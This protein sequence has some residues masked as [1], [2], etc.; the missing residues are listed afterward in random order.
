MLESI[1][2]TWDI[3]LWGWNFD[4]I[5][6]LNVMHDVSPAVMLFNQE[7]MRSAITPF[8][9]DKTSPHLLPLDKCFGIPAYT[10]SPQGALAL[11]KNCFPLKNFSLFFPV[12]N[13]SLPNKGIDIA[14]NKNYKQ[15]NAYVSFP[16]MV[17]TKNDHTISTIQNNKHF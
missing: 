1:S 10:I 13:R 17:V 9:Q 12:L 8:Q 15:L 3:I 5:L 7:Q 11:K 6:S 4:S 14:M 16:P 2:S